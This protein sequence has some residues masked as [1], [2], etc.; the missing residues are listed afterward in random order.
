MI[1]PL[2]DAVSGERVQKPIVRIVHHRCVNAR[3]GIRERSKHRL[4]T[5]VFS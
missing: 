4:I 5:R 1:G 2:H 3:D